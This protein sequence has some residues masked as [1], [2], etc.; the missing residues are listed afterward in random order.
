MKRKEIIVNIA[1]AGLFCALICVGA[2]IKIPI[3]NLPITMQVFFVLLSG[4][5]LPP[6]TAFLANFSYMFLGLIGIPLF[7]G[8]G[9][10]GYVLVPSFGYIL[11]FVAASPIISFFLSKI[12]KNSFWIFLVAGFIGILIIYAIGVPYF[13]LIMNVYKAGGKSAMWFIKALV[14]PFIPKEVISTL[15]AVLVGWKVRPLIEKIK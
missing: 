4:L 5:I 7:T 2:F 3:P 10:I 15:A 9:G 1:L 6:Q 12:K 14:I 8:G 13:A 11:G